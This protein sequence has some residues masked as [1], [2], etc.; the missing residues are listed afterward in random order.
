MRNFIHILGGFSLVYLV[1]PLTGFYTYSGVSNSI[2][3]I[4]VCWLFSFCAGGFYE[5]I[6]T[7][8]D[9]EQKADWND[10]YRTSIGGALAGIAVLFPFNFYILAITSIISLVAVA[11]EIHRIL[12]KK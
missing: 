12:N 8:I 9:K 1:S 11:Y 5:F 2:C 7:T 6:S 4:L 3:I 10:V